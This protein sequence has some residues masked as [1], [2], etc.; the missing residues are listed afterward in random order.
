V[1][2]F[3]KIITIRVPHRISGFFEIVDQLNG[4][5][6]EDPLKIGSRGAGFNVNAFGK[7]VISYKKIK[8]NEDSQ[9][10]IYINGVEVNEQAETTFYIFKVIEKYLKFRVKT[11][12][13]HFFDLP[14][15]CGY[16]ASGSGA[17]GTIFGLNQLFHLNLNRYECGAIAHTSEVINKTGLGTVCGQIGGG[18]CIL[19]EPGYPCKTEQ[20]KVPKNLIVICAS[21]GKIAT[22]SILSDPILSKRIKEAGRIA[23]N[24]L[25]SKP[26]SMNFMKCSIEFV[27]QSEI[28]EALKLDDLQSLL[29]DLNKL[30]II[31]ASMNQLGRSIYV[32]CKEEKRNS[33]QDV[34]KAF[35]ATVPVFCLNVYNG[36]SIIFERG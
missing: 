9:C 35:N 30:E 23:L 2:K 17:L 12:I 6:L 4:K 10:I 19:K 1:L 18:L 13:E 8:D 7:T 33:V 26:N 14:V 15:G 11:K 29:N 21:Y 5:F 27:K 34:F 3:T 24:H 31:G 32:F 16:G 28:I 22:K 36:D 20:I 25:L